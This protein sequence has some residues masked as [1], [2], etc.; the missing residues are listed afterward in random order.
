MSER[1]LPG[2]S[3]TRFV[4]R[5]SARLSYEAIGEPAAPALVALH[6]LLAQRGVWRPWA[7]ML[8]EAGLRLIA[9]DARGHG[10]SAALGGRAYPVAELAADVLAVLDN[11]GVATAHLAG[12]GWGAATALAVAR[13][14]PE[15]VGA[16]LLIQPDL[17]GILAGDASPAARWAAETARE[18]LSTAAVAADKGMTDRALDI[19]LNPRWGAEWRARLPRPR[20]SAIRRNAGSLGAILGGASVEGPTAQMLEG[21][22][23]PTL[24]LVG[25]NASERDRLVAERLAAAL[26]G[27][28]LE[29]AALIDSD[30]LVDPGAEAAVAAVAAFLRDL[31]PR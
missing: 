31:A 26:A 12:H 6:D 5:G 20:L 14:A 3:I 15:R 9:I 30:G 11:E 16:L 10:A 1:A 18:L 19:L 25:A 27:A 8:A 22:N 7:E 24:V 2:A 4:A 23:A 28:S 13:G 29:R 21:F 17:P